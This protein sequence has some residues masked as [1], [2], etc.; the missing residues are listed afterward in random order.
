MNFNYSY[1]AFL[2]TCLLFGILVLTLWSIKLSS[3]IVPEEETA[4]IEYEDLIIE[5]PEEDIALT[6]QKK[7]SIKTNRAYNEAEKFIKE[8]EN[9]REENEETNENKLNENFSESIESAATQNALEEAKK[10]IEQQRKKAAEAKAAKPT[11]SSSKG[12]VTRTT[13]SY[14]LVDRKA[15]RLPNPVFTCEGGGKVVISIEVNKL[16]NVTK[17]SYN[18]SASTT[19][20]GCL[21]DSALDYAQRSR[22][23]TKADIEEQMGT[24]T[25]NFPGQN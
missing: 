3:E 15:M 9:N 8:L 23:N 5:E 19:R 24:I 11:T 18:K 6:E 13:I 22:F 12:A 7:V 21:I 1:R 16:G 10:R 17:A 25:Y 14:S 2:I 20:N 4:P